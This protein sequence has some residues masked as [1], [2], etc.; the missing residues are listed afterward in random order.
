MEMV[1]SYHL[2]V[3]R[4][5]IIYVA[6]ENVTLRV[7]VQR[8]SQLLMAHAHAEVNAMLLLV[9]IVQVHYK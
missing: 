9:L 5:S 4:D 7:D 6:M 1:C 8:D 3:V 2:R